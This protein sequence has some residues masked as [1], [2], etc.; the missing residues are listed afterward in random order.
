MRMHRGICLSLA[1]LMLVAGCGQPIMVAGQMAAPVRQ[2]AATPSAE[3]M[4][5]EFASGFATDD[6]FKATRRGT[7]V[8]VSGPEGILLTYDFTRTPQ[9]GTVTVRSGAT[10]TEIKVDANTP[11]VTGWFIAKIAIRMVYG[12]VKAYIKYTKS[13]TGSDYNR[14]DLVKAVVYGMLSQ[15]VAGLPGGFL[16]KRL[17]PI[18]W[19]WIF[20]EP[21][22][23][24]RTS[25]AKAIYERWSKDLPQ[26][27]AILREYQKQGG[28]LQ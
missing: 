16:W 1:T 14:E 13:H 27:E 19:E 3:A 23:I 2:A 10:T 26:I 20:N 24:P 12:G 28:Q 22:I 4:A 6:T 15:G 7:V 5:A 11:K 9:T 17:M 8:T 21:P 25:T 18:V